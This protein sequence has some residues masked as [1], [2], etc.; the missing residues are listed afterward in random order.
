MLWPLDQLHA[1]LSANGM[2]EPFQS[3]YR[4]GHS[5]EIALVRVQNDIFGGHGSEKGSHAAAS[6]GPLHHS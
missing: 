2:Y 5:T 4:K 1:Y 3:G 6:L